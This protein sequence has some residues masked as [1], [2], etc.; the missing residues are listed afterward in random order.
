MICI[1]MCWWDARSDPTK[2]DLS[3][4][5]WV[6]RYDDDDE[7][8]VRTMR[9][10]QIRNSPALKIILVSH[11]DYPIDIVHREK[12]SCPAVLFREKSVSSRA[13]PWKKVR[14][15]IWADSL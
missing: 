6:I 11:S 15:K 1:V 14:S 7:N 13:I 9:D 3:P 2:I 4:N 12:P 10:S 5:G 8:D